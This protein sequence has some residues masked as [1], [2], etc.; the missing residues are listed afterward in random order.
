MDVM[1]IVAMQ[2]VFDDKMLIQLSTLSRRVVTGLARRQAIRHQMQLGKAVRLLR[3]HEDRR[4]YSQVLRL[5]HSTH[6][7]LNSTLQA[8]VF[9]RSCADLAEVWESIHAGLNRA[10]RRELTNAEA[11]QWSLRHERYM[12]RQ[13]ERE[14]DHEVI[15]EESSGLDS[16]YEPDE[17]EQVDWVVE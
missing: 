16:G 6:R 1:A 8:L 11:V 15:D 7:A 4:R 5:L 10:L 12:R 17:S 14:D 3:L 9:T 13:R 2:D